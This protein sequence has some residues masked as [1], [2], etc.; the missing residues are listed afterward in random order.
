MLKKSLRKTYPYGPLN[1]QSLYSY[2][3]ISTLFLNQGCGDAF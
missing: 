2:A 1:P 3:F